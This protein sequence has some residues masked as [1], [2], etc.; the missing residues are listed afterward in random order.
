MLV[1]RKSA[2]SGN[3]NTMDLNVTQDQLDLYAQGKELIQNVFP[4]LNPD[5]REFIKTGVTKK[6]WDDMF[7]SE[8]EED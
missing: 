3:T 2:F 8:E 1:T 7:G 5:E 4:N 6:E